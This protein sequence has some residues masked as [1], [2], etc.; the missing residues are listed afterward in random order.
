MMEIPL[1]G[2]DSRGEVQLVGV[3]FLFVFV[4]LVGIFLLSS[5]KWP[6]LVS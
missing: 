1:S 5:S 2:K 4:K 6:T 3:Y